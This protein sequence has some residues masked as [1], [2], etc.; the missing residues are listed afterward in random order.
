[1]N[2]NIKLV[3]VALAISILKV[4]IVI[5]QGDRDGHK[6]RLNETVSRP[7]RQRLITSIYPWT[8]YFHAMS[9]SPFTFGTLGPEDPASPPRGG[10]SKKWGGRVPPVPIGSYAHDFT[11]RRCS[12]AGEAR[13]EASE[14]AQPTL[15]DCMS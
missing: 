1:L 14:L 15:R 11:C 6:R 3:D 7:M 5:S 12:S 10:R 8:K 4:F 2:Y 13:L 9:S